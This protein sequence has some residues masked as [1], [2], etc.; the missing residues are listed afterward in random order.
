[1]RGDIQLLRASLCGIVTIMINRA[2]E[3]QLIWYLAARSTIKA[4]YLEE[5]I[6]CVNEISFKSVNLKYEC[7][8]FKKKVLKLNVTNIAPVLI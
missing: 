3:K 7:Y 5:K 4:I 1:M 8:P 6:M 2:Y